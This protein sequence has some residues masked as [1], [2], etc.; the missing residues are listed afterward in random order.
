MHPFYKHCQ[1]MLYILHD[2]YVVVPYKQAVARMFADYLGRCSDLP[3]QH[4]PR[5]AALADNARI[6]ADNCNTAATFAASLDN[7]M[8]EA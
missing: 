1:T 2:D 4:L 3:L 6:Y 5:Y 7:E 8:A